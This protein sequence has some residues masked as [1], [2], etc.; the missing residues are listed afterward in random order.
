MYYVY[1]CLERAYTACMDVRTFFN[2]NSKL[3]QYVRATAG[4]FPS[5]Y[6]RRAGVE[7]T[8]AYEPRVGR[9]RIYAGLQSRLMN[10]R[11]K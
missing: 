4:E 5:K 11:T 3:L 1:A 6:N 8:M 2:S 10:W 9:V 7:S